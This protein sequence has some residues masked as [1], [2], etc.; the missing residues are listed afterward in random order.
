MSRFQDKLKDLIQEAEEIRDQ[1]KQINN[2]SHE[3]LEMKQSTINELRSYKHPQLIVVDIM[4]A[5]F[6]V[7]GVKPVFVQVNFLLPRLLLNYNQIN[8]YKYDTSA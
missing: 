4:M 6:L 3:I 7:L 1:L 8:C 2:I 5:T